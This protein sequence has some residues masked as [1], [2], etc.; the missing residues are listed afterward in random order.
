MFITLSTINGFPLMVLREV[1]YEN[2]NVSASYLKTILVIFQ[3]SL[4]EFNR[5][6]H[7]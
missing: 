1:I 6:I 7:V 3:F 4:M 2:M 5:T